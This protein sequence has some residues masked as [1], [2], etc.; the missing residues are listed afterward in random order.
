MRVIPAF[1]LHCNKYLAI[2]LQC[3]NPGM[4]N[5]EPVSHL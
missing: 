4:Y 2:I 3:V 5:L 1:M